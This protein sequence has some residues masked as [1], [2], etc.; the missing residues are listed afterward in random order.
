MINATGILIYSQ[1]KT[2]YSYYRKHIVWTIYKIGNI[3]SILCILIMSFITLGPKSQ[4]SDGESNHFRNDLGTGLGS[5]SRCGINWSSFF[6]LHF[7]ILSAAMLAKLLKM[8][9][10]LFIL[11][12]GQC[13]K[14]VSGTW[15]GQWSQ[16]SNHWPLTNQQCDLVT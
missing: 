10:N 4:S 6:Q 7:E 14:L 15:S 1:L 8:L 3:G 2:I 5:K 9:S 13:W 16:T 11:L 12:V